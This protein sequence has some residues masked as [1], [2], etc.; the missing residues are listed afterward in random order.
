[1]NVGAATDGSHEYVDE[2]NGVGISSNSS[3]TFNVATSGT[4]FKLTLVWSDY[5]S[6][7]TAAPDL[8]NDLDLTVT[9]PAG[10]VYH[11]NVLSGDWS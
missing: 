11:G 9:A 4:T 10:A 1:M 6:T 7:E 3:Y 2:T 8:A 5:P